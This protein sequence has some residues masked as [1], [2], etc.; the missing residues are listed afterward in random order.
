MGAPVRHRIELDAM[1]ELHPCFGLFE[2]AVKFLVVPLVLPEAFPQIA[3]FREVLK[4]VRFAR[5][6]TVSL[7]KRSYGSYDGCFL[8]NSC[9]TDGAQDDQT[10][11]QQPSRRLENQT[12]G[13]PDGYV[14]Q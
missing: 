6:G 3:E 10:G 8:S 14:I 7:S 13:R 5:R 12:D 1:G 9:T 4:L 11:V 2:S